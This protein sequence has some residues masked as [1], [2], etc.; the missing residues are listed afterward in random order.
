MNE[1]TITAV[2]ILAFLST[3]P[4]AV[5]ALRIVRI[6][7]RGRPIWDLLVAS[8]KYLD[9]SRYPPK[10]I[11]LSVQMRRWAFVF[12]LLIVLAGVLRV[13]VTSGILPP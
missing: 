1:W 3:L 4:A 7:G 6:H 11:A 12:F 13:L 5:L 9:L 10:A 8:P 2:T